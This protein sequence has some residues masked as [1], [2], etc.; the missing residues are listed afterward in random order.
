M[1]RICL[2][3][4]A[5]S[6]GL[7]GCFHSPPPAHR[8]DPER[9]RLRVA[10]QQDLAD[11]LRAVPGTAALLFVDLDT[12]ET[13]AFDA[14]RPFHAASVIKLFILADA[15]QHAYEGTLDL[16]A[17]VDLAAT[18]PGATDGTPFAAGDEGALR[19]AAGPRPTARRLCEQMV[20]VSSNSAANNLMLRL[21]G[22][23]AVEQAA[24][25]FGA[26]RTRIPRYLMDEAA[27]RAG[28]SHETTAADVG[29]LLE[30][31]A[32]RLVV[33]PESSTEMA[34]LLARA[35]G[36]FLPRLLPASDTEVAH[37]PG[38]IAGVRHDAG[39]VTGSNGTYVLVVLMQDLKDEAAGERAGAEISR[40]CYDYVLARP[41]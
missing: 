41:R 9:D 19:A 13:L 39:F 34:R 10:L 30:R 3:V 35:E 4:A 16:D 23:A 20:V 26:A 36:G 2:A 32:R 24:R 22:P 5:L 1:M 11:R 31:I 7:A 14:E 25:A 27:H 15:F 17:E 8:P 18:F 21:G 38:A 29:G 6:A 12:D 40:R 37:K 33:S 28:L